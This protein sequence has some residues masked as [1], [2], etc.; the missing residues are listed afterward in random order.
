MIAWVNTSM[1][2]SIAS[3]PFYYLSTS[4]NATL[5][6]SFF[7]LEYGAITL[8]S[9]KE[10]AIAAGTHGTYGYLHEYRLTGIKRNRWYFRDKPA[11]NY[12]DR[13][14]ELLKNCDNPPSD[15]VKEAD[16]LI[17]NFGMNERVV[18]EIYAD[19]YNDPFQFIYDMH[20]YY[21][22]DGYVARIQDIRFLQ[23]G[24]TVNNEKWHVARLYTTEPLVHTRNVTKV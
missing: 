4:E 17:K 10:R 3:I 18:S 14:I 5:D 2:R 6:I 21:G 11:L 24:E 20:T 7:G 12:R 13:F 19:Y 23:T 8:W 22:V 16:R 9:Q 1:S 15:P